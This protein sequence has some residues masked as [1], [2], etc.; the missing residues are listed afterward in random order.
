MLQRFGNGLEMVTAG[1]LGPLA[2]ISVAFLPLEPIMGDGLRPPAALQGFNTL[3][4]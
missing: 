1:G 4:G 3:R 2:Q